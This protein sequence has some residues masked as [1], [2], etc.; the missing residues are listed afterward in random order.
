MTELDKIRAM[1]MDAIIILDDLRAQKE[2]LEED[3][4]KQS[5][6]QWT[7]E[8]AKINVDVGHSI[9]SEELMRRPFTVEDI[10]RIQLAEQWEIDKAGAVRRVAPTGTAMTQR[11]DAGSKEFSAQLTDKVNRA[12]DEAG[13]D[14]LAAVTKLYDSGA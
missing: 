8:V 9:K 5:A 13:K 1:L 14:M 3:R 2:R 4:R 10:V 6:L 12:L 11:V 7:E